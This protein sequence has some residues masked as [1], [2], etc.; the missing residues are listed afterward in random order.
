[1]KLKKLIALILTLALIMTLAPVAFAQGGF[2]D[3]SESSVYYEA[4]QWALSEGVTAGVDATHFAPNAPCTR[5]QVVTLLWRA[6]GSPEVSGDNPFVDVKDGS[7]YYTAILWAAENG[8]TVGYDKTHFCPDKTVTR[9]EFVTFLYRYFGSPYTSGANPF[10]D[11]S[12]YSPYR[13]AIVWASRSGVTVGF[14][15][16]HFRP[17]MTCTRWQVVLFLFRAFGTVTYYVDSV[18]GSDKNDGRSPDTAFKTLFKAF[19]RKFYPG[20]H[21]LFKCGGTYEGGKNTAGAYIKSSGLKTNPIVL[22]SYG[23]GA[24]PVITTEADERLLC[25]EGSFINISG[26]DF[27]APNGGGIGI[28]CT[29][30]TDVEGINISHCRFYNIHPDKPKDSDSDW[31]SLYLDSDYATRAYN[32][33]FTDL[34]IFD[35]YAGIEVSGTT[36]EFNHG[37]FVSPEANYHYNLLFDGINCH[38]VWC[39][40][41]VLGAMRDCVVRNSR[42]INCARDVSWAVAPMW[43]HG[44]DNVMMEYCE[45]AGST[46]LI[47]GM[48]IDFDGWTTNC[49]YRYIYSHDN[50]RFM[51]NCIYDAATANR[52]N[53]V[54]HCLSVND[55][56]FP[57]DSA[58]PLFNESTLKANGGKIGIIM[59]D[60]SFTNNYLIDCSPTFFG[61]LSNATITGNYFGGKTFLTA[62]SSAMWSVPSSLCS[63][64]VENNVFYMYTPML[65]EG[66]TVTTE[67]ISAETAYSILFPNGVHTP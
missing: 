1:M 23:E 61:N 17:D 11:V 63:G 2:T 26:L 46:N 9:A 31:Y 27:T 24:N 34:E 8:I 16:T 33:S 35:C 20:T 5:G 41:L 67:P 19:N 6:A 28:F 47:D 22:G 66:N 3:V 50:N 29:A 25:L 7:P 4:V 53:T 51:R 14:D 64:T 42:F 57:N 21:V 18:D 39:G 37:C 32:C 36:L 60:F 55:N 15:S 54:D 49:T 38:E 40:G 48:A 30:T 45:I 43:T 10:V 44:C 62:S 59:E 58:L 13:D 65:S 56:V 12:E 52:G